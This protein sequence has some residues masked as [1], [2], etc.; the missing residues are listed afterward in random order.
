MLPLQGGGASAANGFGKPNVTGM[1]N[2]RDK[3]KN[4]VFR[5]P[6]GSA[7]L[8]YAAPSGRECWEWEFCGATYYF[9]VRYN[10][11]KK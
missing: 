7:G 2:R 1:I 3:G 5:Y 8:S 11:C 10:S 6:A 9:T 4:G